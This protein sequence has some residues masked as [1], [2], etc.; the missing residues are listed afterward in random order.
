M[1]RRLVLVLVLLVIWTGLLAWA[2]GIPWSAPWSA[3]ENLALSG[4]DFRVQFGRGSSERDALAVHALGDDGTGLQTARVSGVRAAAFPLLRY[5][6]DE[7]PDTLELAF[8]FRRS[9]TSDEVQTI[10]LP[11]PYRGEVAVDLSRFKEWRGDITEV[12]FAEYATAQLVPPSAASSFHPFRIQ[13][14]VLQSPTWDTVF[15]RLRSDWF[16]YRPWAQQSINTIGPGV[17]VLGRSWMLPVLALGAVASW[18]VAW[19]ILRWSRARAAKAACIIAACA[20]LLLDLRWLDDLFAK[21]R[22]T[23]EIYAGKPWAQREALQPDEGT[24]A[25]AA[26]VARIAAQHH[27]GRVLVHSDSIYTLLRF[28]YFLLPLN[29]APLMQTTGASGGAALPPDTLIALLGSEW[30]YDEAS[31]RL[32]DGSI[33]IAVKPVY[34]KGDLRIFRPAG[35]VP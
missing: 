5:R 28:T 24:P 23:E 10:S 34:E 1:I 11:A 14:A 7:F 9:D 18:L 31:G 32:G 16:G 21:H 27:V 15:T 29:C 26:E 2:A 25:A 17:G 35:A 19:A 3:R 30:K 13:R 6:I 22:I 8:V 12:G 4:S 20:W 33:G